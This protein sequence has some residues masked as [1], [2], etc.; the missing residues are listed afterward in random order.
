MTRSTSPSPDR[1]GYVYKERFFRSFNHIFDHLNYLIDSNIFTGM[2]LNLIQRKAHLAALAT[3]TAKTAVV[4][5]LHL[6]P[7]LVHLPAPA[8]LPKAAEI[9]LNLK[10]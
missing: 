7:H 3:R 5:A 9:A 1:A 2:I 8:P 4:P 10:T 6:V